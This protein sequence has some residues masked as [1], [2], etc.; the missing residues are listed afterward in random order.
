MKN[1]ESPRNFD[2]TLGVSKKFEKIFE[3]FEENALKSISFN[4]KDLNLGYSIKK[5]NKEEIIEILE[6]FIKK[7]GSFFKKFL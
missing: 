3:F 2:E 7:I 5:L 4:I 6:E 1:R